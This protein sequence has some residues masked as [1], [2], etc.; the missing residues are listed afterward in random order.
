[1]IYESLRN[2]CPRYLCLLHNHELRI[3]HMIFL[4]QFALFVVVY[5]YSRIICGLS[6]DL[7][8]TEDNNIWKEGTGGGDEPA[9]V[10]PEMFVILNKVIYDVDC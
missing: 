4:L 7:N 6:N 3:F 8:G 1:M 5:D 10:L 2:N 9:I